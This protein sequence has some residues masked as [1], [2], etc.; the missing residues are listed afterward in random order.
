[1]TALLREAEFKK[2]VMQLVFM[3]AHINKF[4]PNIGVR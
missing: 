3:E 1:M 4:M 2:N